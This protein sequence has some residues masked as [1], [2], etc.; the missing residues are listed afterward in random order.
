MSDTGYILKEVEMANMPAM[1][2][3]LRQ[4]AG[5]SF[6][7][8]CKEALRI[9]IMLNLVVSFVLGGTRYYV[10]PDDILEEVISR[11]SHVKEVR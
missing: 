8:A 6:R 5:A 4:T 3:E 2:L 10:C 11:F 1:T 7:D 9:A